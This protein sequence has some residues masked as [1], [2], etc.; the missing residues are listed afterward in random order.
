MIFTPFANVAEKVPQVM[1]KLNTISGATAYNVTVKIDINYDD[2]SGTRTV[3]YTF[4]DVPN[5]GTY[6]TPFIN[7]PVLYTPNNNPFG[8]I[9][10]DVDVC[11]VGDTGTVDNMSIKLSQ[12]KTYFTAD[13]WVELINFNNATNLSLPNCS[14][15][16]RNYFTANV[17]AGLI[18]YDELYLVEVTLT[19]E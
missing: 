7:N 15:S 10:C 8:D 16:V 18:T 12:G 2:G 19:T 3:S 9:G 11:R 4:T 6:V 1:F 5:S 13:N 17:S 14:S